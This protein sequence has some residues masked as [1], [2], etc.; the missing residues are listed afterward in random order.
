MR[1]T[2][3]SVIPTKAQCNQL[4][5]NHYYYTSSVTSFGVYLAITHVSAVSLKYCRL[6]SFISSTEIVK[7]RRLVMIR[8]ITG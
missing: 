6:L 2:V 8:G 3:K 7:V 4:R 1:A 5:N